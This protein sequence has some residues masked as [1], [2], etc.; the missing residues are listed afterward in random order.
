MKIRRLPNTD[1]AR[2]AVMSTDAKWHALRHHKAGWAKF[3]YQP[4][5]KL[6][7]DLLNAKVG[8]FERA[9][10]TPFY[11]IEK[12]L[13]K[14]CKRGDYEL[15]QNLLIAN[16]IR[17]MVERTN[18]EAKCESFGEFPLRI[19]DSTRF[20]EHMITRLDGGYV[21]PF[22]DFRRQKGITGTSKKFVFSMMHEHIRVANPD[23]E[24]LG[25]AIM[26]FPTIDE[27]SRGYS[28]DICN[29]DK[30]FTFDELDM[31]IRE[32][33]DIWALVLAERAEEAHRHDA[34]AGGGF[35]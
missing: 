14:N 7:P 12:L 33:Y 24:S 21:V 9:D 13:W 2:F 19:G 8:F 34:G 1:L 17:L 16:A 15:K 35:I 23:Y 11:Q 18:V 5:R 22:F 25:L 10:K 3:S 20:W 28:F 27:E 6:I 4:V 30:L 32:T 29:E 31:M 26:K